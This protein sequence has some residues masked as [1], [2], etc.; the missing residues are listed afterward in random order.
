M[1]SSKDHPRT[2]GEKSGYSH[3]ILPFKG[4]PPHTRGKG[5]DRFPAL[6]RSRITPAHAGKSSDTDAF[7]GRRWDHPRT[8]GEKSSTI[9]ASLFLTGSPPHTR[10][11]VSV[12]PRSESPEGI[13]PAHAGKRKLGTV[14][15]Q[16]SRDH[17]RTRGE[18]KIFTPFSVTTLG[19]PPHTRGKDCKAIPEL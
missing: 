16:A 19:S 18:K 10:G 3:I 13:T 4:S 12:L 6:W 11:K 1:F 17:P 9:T 7:E 5:K 15:R 14:L 8:R 2:R